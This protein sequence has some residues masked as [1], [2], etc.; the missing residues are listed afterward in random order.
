MPATPGQMSYANT[1]T[2]YNLLTGQ[3]MQQTGAVN[4]LTGQPM[5]GYNSELPFN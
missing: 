2:S 4:P 5:Q 1:G 3:P